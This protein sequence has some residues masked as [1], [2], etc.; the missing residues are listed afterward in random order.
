MRSQGPGW[1]WTWRLGLAVLVVALAAACSPAA[2]HTGPTA[3]QAASGT[4]N[5][6]AAASALDSQRTAY[7]SVMLDGSPGTPTA[8]A[9]TGTLYVPIQCPGSFCSTDKPAHVVDVIN[10]ATCNAKMRSGCQVVARATVGDSPNAAVVDDKTDTVVQ[11]YPDEAVLRR[12]AYFHAL[13]LTKSEPTRIL[14]TDRKA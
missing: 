2:G 11:Q 1:S 12:R 3:T 6:P 8:N 9:R 4:G 10:A 7:G 5:H 13:D 14:A